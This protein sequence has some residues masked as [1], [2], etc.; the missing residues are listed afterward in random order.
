VDILGHRG[1]PFMARRNYRIELQHLLPWG[2][3]AG[4]F[5]GTVSSIIAAKTFDAGPWLIAVVVASPMFANLLGLYWGALATG[6]RKLPLFISF[7]MAATAMLASVALVPQ[8]P[9]GGYIFAA[10]VI[11]ARVLLSACMTFR[12]SLWKHNYAA[13]VRG[14]IAAR[15]QF[16]RFSMAIITVTAASLLFDWNPAVYRIVYPACALIGLFG[17]L[18]LRRLHVRGERAELAAIARNNH[19][20]WPVGAGITGAIRGM[21]A[22]FRADRDFARYCLA[23]M[24]LGFA[25][26]MIMPI[27]TIIVTKQLYL[28]Y[29]HSCNLLEVLPRVLLMGSL[30]SWAG[31]FD[32]VGVVRFRVLNAGIWSTMI[33]CGGIGAALIAYAGIEASMPMFVL[34]ITFIAISR[35]FQGLGKGG[36][37]I[38]WNLGHLHFA[39]PARAEMYMGTHVFLTGI[40][41]ITAPL[42]GTWLYIAYGPVAFAVALACALLGLSQFAALARK[43]RA[44]AD[45]LE[46]QHHA[47]PHTTDTQ[48]QSPTIII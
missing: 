41:G 9:T 28:S 10:Q 5:E 33:L 23:M 42:L 36:G 1:V 37:A 17:I 32:R 15:L 27:M 45:D 16:V 20:H 40:R 4:M 2:I 19:P 14:R 46:S 12:A 29:Y 26:V 13:S 21:A 7:A 30:M 31:L 38:A 25:N 24:F 3:F 43:Q 44:D 18:R 11:I 35:S 22:L 39:E 6:R 48:P 34:A 47:Q 8:S